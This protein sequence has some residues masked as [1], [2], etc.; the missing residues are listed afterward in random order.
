MKKKWQNVKV[1]R[2]REASL[3]LILLAGLG[4]S[5][6]ATTG[7]EASS[8]INDPFEEFNRGMFAVN[9]AVDQVLM[10]PVAKAYRAVTPKELRKG[11]HNIL[12]NLKSPITFANQVLQG[13]FEGAGNVLLRTTLNTFAGMGGLMDVA[14]AEGIEDEPE[15]FGQTLAVWG[16]GHG[17]YIV[18]PILGPS[19][20]RDA[21]GLAVDTFA[22][23]LRLYLH[24]TDQEEWYY[25]R[26]AAIGIDKREALLDVLDDLR[27]SSFDYYAALRSA[28]YQRRA[29]LVNDES[30]EN[31]TAPVIPDYDDMDEEE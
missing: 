31:S 5:G 16:M 28:Y 25:A 14:A 21:T 11:V 12:T 29:A 18:L 30:P 13:D 22:D 17:P 9:D 23:P 20:L 4:L 7:Q 1:D 15:D 10:R 27:S 6:C 24:N 2:F 8:Q 26:V 19:S 3:A